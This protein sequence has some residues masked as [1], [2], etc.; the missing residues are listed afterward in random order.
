M[1]IGSVVILGIIAVLMSGVVAV[2]FLH[3]DNKTFS[4]ESSGQLCCKN[5]TYSNNS[6]LA[7]ITGRIS[8]AKGDIVSLQENQAGDLSWIASGSWNLSRIA[9]EANF[10]ARFTMIKIDSSEKHRY[11]ISDFNLT[12]STTD[13]YATTLN[14]TATVRLAGAV[15]TD[16][17]ISVRI[18]DQGVGDQTIGI[19]I[20]PNRVQNHFGHT[21]IYGYVNKL[22]H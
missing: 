20:N 6:S 3:T 12:N 14:G 19:W 21:P 16:V 10:N 13:A 9:D 18:M 8:L 11:R 15:L 17:P 4:Q 1:N 7:N 5:T 2:T 22:V